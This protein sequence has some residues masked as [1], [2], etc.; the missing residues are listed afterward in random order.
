MTVDLIF[1][2]TNETYIVNNR[3]FCRYLSEIHFVFCFCFLIFGDIS[4]FCG[5]TDAPVF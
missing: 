1:V 5:A 2:A 4:P 3:K